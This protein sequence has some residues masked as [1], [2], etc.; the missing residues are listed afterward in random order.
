[1]L[2]RNPSLVDSLFLALFDA[3]ESLA[4]HGVP[5]DELAIM[6]SGDLD[7]ERTLEKMKIFSLMIQANN[8]DII[9]E[10]TAGRPA[11]APEVK[12]EDHGAY[13]KICGLFPFRDIRDGHGDT[14]GYA[15]L[16]QLST[17]LGAVAVRMAERALDME[18]VPYADAGFSISKSKDGDSVAWKTIEIHFCTIPQEKDAA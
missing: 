7:R 8:G 1:M 11:P 6:V 18:S 15:V 13:L 4:G 10:Q 14:A 5:L 9:Q 2:N 17:T 16:D 12:V 3:A